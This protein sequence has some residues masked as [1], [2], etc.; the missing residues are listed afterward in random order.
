MLLR[1]LTPINFSGAWFGRV[2][3]P[4]AN[5]RLL[6]VQESLEDDLTHFYNFIPSHALAA[7]N[8]STQRI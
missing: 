4:F 6:T 8:G 3:I 5:A 1:I 7:R 2:H